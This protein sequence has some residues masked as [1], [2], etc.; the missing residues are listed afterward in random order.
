MLILDRVVKISELSQI[1]E[2]IFFSDM[3]MMKAVADIDR[4]VLAVNGELHSDLEQM[5]LEN[6]SKQQHLYGINIYYDGEIEFDS[7]INPPRNREAGYPRAGRG[8]ADPEAREKIKEVVERWIS[9]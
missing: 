4:L 8:V 1:E 2:K 6:G 9:Q 3:E 5:L 7:M